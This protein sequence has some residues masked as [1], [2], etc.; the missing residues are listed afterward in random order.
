MFPYQSRLSLT[1]HSVQS[2]D[3]IY[4]GKIKISAKDFSEHF[5]QN[6]ADDFSFNSKLT[7]VKKDNKINAYFKIDKTV[8]KV[9]SEVA[10]I[11]GKG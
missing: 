10:S 9:L 5:S 11:T 2:A 4:E 1:R 3:K 7:Y 6:V 8:P